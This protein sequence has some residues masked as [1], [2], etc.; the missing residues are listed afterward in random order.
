MG[1]IAFSAAIALALGACGGD[2][3]TLNNQQMDETIRNLAE[4]AGPPDDRPPRTA[5]IEIR[6]DELERSMPS[7]AGCDFS[8]DGRLLFATAATGQAF[9]KVNGLPVRFAA[10][11][12]VGATG[13]YFVAEG[14]SVSIGR[15][16]DSGVTVEE[17]TTWPARL[18]FTDRRRETE[19]EVRIEGAWRCG[20]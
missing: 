3:P 15:L 18:L 11:G 7:G 6:R 19:N 10:S 4:E 12:P 16:T 20:A 8:E 2:E 14:Y 5:L 13:G 9:A 17:T 1:R